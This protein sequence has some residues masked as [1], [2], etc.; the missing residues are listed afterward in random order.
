MHLT[1]NSRAATM[2]GWGKGCLVRR[3]IRFGLY[4]EAGY[5]ILQHVPSLTAEFTLVFAV[6]LSVVAAVGWM[7][8]LLVLLL[9]TLS[10]IITL[11]RHY[12]IKAYRKR[13]SAR[14][15]CQHVS[16]VGSPTVRMNVTVEKPPHW[17]RLLYWIQER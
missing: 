16:T 17:K 10:A 15:E 13:L 4:A 6:M 11:G 2:G 5:A 3:A 9:L 14:R 12:G 8:V 1:R 7:D